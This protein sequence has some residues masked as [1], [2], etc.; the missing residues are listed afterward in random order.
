VMGVGEDVRV[1]GRKRADYRQGD[2]T[3]NVITNSHGSIRARLGETD[4]IVATKVD[5]G[6]P[7]LSRPDQG[8][9]KF[10]VD[11][12]PTA[13]PDFEGRG[14]DELAEKICR[15]LSIAYD[16]SGTID[17]KTLC[18]KSQKY[19]YIVNV[20]ILVL[21]CG[22]N[23]IDVISMA[24]KLCLGI[25]ELPRVT[26]VRYDLGQGVPVFSGDEFE[27]D[28]LDVSKSPVVVTLPRV[29]RYFVVDASL[30]EESCSKGKLAFG[31]SPDGCVTSIDKL[32]RGCYQV[33][34]I[35]NATQMASEVGAKVN[36]T[37]NARIGALR[38]TKLRSEKKPD[39]SALKTML[40]DIS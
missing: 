2:V 20:D 40:M 9:I 16:K 35:K 31:V 29:G 22:G 5:L 6:T 39:E 4:V 33:K 17:L 7:E 34:S 18:I 3:P 28:Y 30:E 21:Q 11:C 8:S 36:K 37:V 38:L 13:S 19:C 15:I 24:V 12:S 10:L 32:G 23:L 27:F 1:D 25:C 14:G 26:G